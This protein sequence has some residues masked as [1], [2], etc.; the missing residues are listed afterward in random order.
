MLKKLDEVFDVTMFTL[1]FRMQVKNN[2]SIKLV[3]IMNVE[4]KKN[5]ELG[6]K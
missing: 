3:N 1:Y 6:K 4:N 5:K 2:L